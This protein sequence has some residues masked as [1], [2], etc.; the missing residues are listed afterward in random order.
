VRF[1]GGLRG[2]ISL[3]LALT[4]TAEMVGFET[5]ETI[6]VMTFG[7]VLFTLLVQ[8][9]TMAP[10]IG[11]LGLSGRGRTAL[12]Q[13]EL[14]ARVYMAR[15]GQGEMGRL[16]ADGVLSTDLADA[17]GQTYQRRIGRQSSSLS[18]HFGRH[19][20]LEF[21]MLA[22]A[23]RE[24]LTAELGALADVVRIGLVDQDVADALSIEV[25]TRLAGLDLLSQR[26]ELERSPDGDGRREG[27]AR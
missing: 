22:Q 2:A 3:A 9:T 20:E 25:E 19:P 10:L 12:L 1:W 15:S 16:G 17:V 8:G 21:A 27:G 18:E 13:Q 4:V 24:A 11:R 5:A 14:Q 26:W 6:R 7:V 23:R